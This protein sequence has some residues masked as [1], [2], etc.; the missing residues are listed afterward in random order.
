MAI[1]SV[2]G[3]LCAGKTTFCKWFRDQIPNSVYL[4]I[5]DYR[6]TFSDGTKEGENLSWEELMKDIV[7]YNTKNEVIILETSGTSWRM[8]HIPSDFNILIDTPSQVCYDRCKAKKEWDVPFPWPDKEKSVDS[9]Q[10]LL[11]QRQMFLQMHASDKFAITD[12]ETYKQI[13]SNKNLL[14][15]LNSIQ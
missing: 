7:R 1:I 2:I 5:D 4:A 8:K 9:I 14:T 12:N 6:R 10:M 11:G 15:Y 13:L 3:N